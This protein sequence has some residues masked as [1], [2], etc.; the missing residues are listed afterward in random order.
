MALDLAPHNIRVNCI[1]PGPVDTPLLRSE[2]PAGEEGRE[3]MVEFGKTHP[4]G[5]VSKPIEQAEAILFLASD[6]SSYMTGAPLVI[7]GGFTAA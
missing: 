7:D 3:A 2:F 4:L 1:C 5:R 6:A